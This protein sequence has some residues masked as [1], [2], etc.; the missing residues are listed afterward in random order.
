MRM[1]IITTLAVLSSALCSLAQPPYIHAPVQDQYPKHDPTGVT[2]LPTGRLLRPVGKHT[3]LAQWPHGMCLSPDETTVFVAS[4]GQGQFIRNWKSAA[5]EV[6]NF[7]PSAKKKRSNAGGCAFS[8]NGKTLYWSSGESGEILSIDVESQK[9]L[10]DIS[11][12]VELNGRKFVD[13]F[14]MD[15][16]LGSDGKYLFCADVTNFR[17]AVIDLESA[18]LV[19]SVDVGRYPY[20]L[21]VIG[22][23]AF[24]A[25][26]GA[27][28]YTAIPPPVPGTKPDKSKGE[29][30]IDPRGLTFPPFGLPSEEAV[31]GVYREGRKVPGLGMLNHDSS[32]SV[33]GIDVSDPTKPS[34][35]SRIKTGPQA[36]G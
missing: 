16:Q 12:N 18:K 9:V 23:R 4:G 19:G 36:S 29:K 7:N 1:R 11:L 15:I 34:V 13:S 3:P 6:T 8:K 2:I 22:N 25:N 35:V 20:S 28:E 31:N 26:I 10:A 27:F 21:S 5:P 33:W 14:A 24:V 17:V 32:F 30:V